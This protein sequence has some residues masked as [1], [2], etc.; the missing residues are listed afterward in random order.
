[1][2]SYV[3][4]HGR[5][6]WGQFGEGESVKNKYGYYRT[7]QGVVGECNCIYMYPGTQ[8]HRP[9]HLDDGT[10]NGSCGVLLD[11]ISWLHDKLGI[12]TQQG[13]FRSCQF[14]N[15]V[16]SQYDYALG[17]YIPWHTDAN[18]LFGHNALIASVSLDSPGAFV[19]APRMG[20]DFAN[21]WYHKN[22]A[23]RKEKQK[24]GGVRG[25]LPLFPG[26]VMIMCGTFQENMMHKT[27]P[28]SRITPSIFGDF[29]A[30]NPRLKDSLE[31]LLAVMP[32]IRK[33]KRSVITFRRIARRIK[34]TPSSD[35]PTDVT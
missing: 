9:V 30:V 5:A 33:R 15:V 29:P 25:V 20:T 22:L 10:D 24:Q 21:R 2:R 14:N 1:M 7:V 19:F 31:E 35:V 3:S 12:A 13:G 34:P 17:E 4:S 18:E 6:A 27:L 23:I 28:V 8:K 11:S 16:A 32:S 26:D